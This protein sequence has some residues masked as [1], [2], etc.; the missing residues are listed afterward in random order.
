M[1]RVAASPPLLLS[2]LKI[3]AQFKRLFV[4]PKFLNYRH[5]DNRTRNMRSF[6]LSCHVVNF[7]HS[8][9]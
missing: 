3:P 7:N 9:L 6:A 8:K 2:D 1:L 5:C 4:T